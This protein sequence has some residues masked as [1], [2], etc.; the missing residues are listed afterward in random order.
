MAGT[1]AK[2]KGGLGAETR[3][4]A[5]RMICMLRSLGNAKPWHAEAET[6]KS[7]TYPFMGI[8]RVHKLNLD[9]R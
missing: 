9:M 8:S 2:R 6:T 4:L 1:N 5:L 3:P 7:S